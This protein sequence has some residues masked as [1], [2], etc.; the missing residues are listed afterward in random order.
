MD[1]VFGDTIGLKI[2]KVLGRFSR[3][4]G[5]SRLSDIGICNKRR[6]G[7]SKSVRGWIGVRRV[8]GERGLKV[9]I[10]LSVVGWKWE[11]KIICINCSSSVMIEKMIFMENNIV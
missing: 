1:E 10:I 11:R 4:G 6:L 9:I 8:S 7:G 5:S 2:L 3:A